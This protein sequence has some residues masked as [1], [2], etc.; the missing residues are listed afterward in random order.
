[1]ITNHIKTGAAIALFMASP[2]FVTAKVTLPAIYSDNMIIQQQTEM[3]FSGTANRN[4]DVTISPSWTKKIYT[5]KAN[6]EGKWSIKV[7]TPKA[8]GPYTIVFDDGEKTELKNV[9]AGEVWFCS[10]QSN[11]EMPVAGWGKVMNYEQEIKDANYPNIRLFQV[12]KVTSF[13]PVNETISTMGGW[14]E[15]SSATIPEF[16]AL[17]YFYARQLQQTLKVP[18]GV[19]DCDW[20]G[21]PA[22][23]WISNEALEHVIGY[24]ELLGKMKAVGYNREKIF[25]IYNKESE[26]WKKAVLRSDKGYAEGNPDKTLWTAKNF[27]D[28]D[29]KT[30]QLP[31]YWEKQGLTDFDGVVWFRKNVNIPKEWEGKELQLN[32]GIIDDEDIIYWNG[33][34]IASGGGFNVQRHYT[35][36]ASLVKAGENTLV[37]RVFDT[38]GEGGIAGEASEMNIACP[39]SKQIS[40]AGEWKY[41]IGFDATTLPPA[42]PYPDGSSFPTVLFNAMVHP[43]L[44]YP[45]KGIIWYQ[46]CANVGRAEQYESLFQ[47]LIHDWRKQ[48]GN[49]DMPFYFVQLANFLTR[50]TVQQESPWAALREAQAQALK[51]EGTGMVCNI[52]L[53]EANDIHPKN[54]QAVGKRLAALSLAKT[55][56]KKVAGSAPV[57]DR[58]SVNGDKVTVEFTILEI[59]ENFSP[60]SDI[61]GFTLAGPDHVWHEAQAYTENGKVIVFSDKVKMPVAVR[62]GWANNPECTL[63][64]PSGLKVAPFRSDNW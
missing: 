13:V 43:W 53:G 2:V 48:F 58:Y 35:I 39:N 34:K 62:Y 24:E 4:A 26:E 6:S 18:V 1:M 55:Y 21:T 15:C 17:A 57:Y 27:N 23:A 8:G 31:A 41:S 60:N 3:T 61:K 52:D 5:A 49:P 37:I 14:Q 40:L 50:Q 45:V 51:I 32:P 25:D 63:G 47:T 22:E 59:G 29:W 10:G 38:G 46:G 36:P 12:K 28:S 64:T 9:L 42:P 56:G 54:K 7:Q 20:G 30:M 33:E 19:I 44:N 11:M 16:S